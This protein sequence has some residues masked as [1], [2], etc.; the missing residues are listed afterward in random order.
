MVSLRKWSIAAAAVLSWS[1]SLVS[2]GIIRHDVSDQTY[3]D[4]AQESQFQAVGFI[5][6]TTSQY[7]YSASG[8]LINNQWVLT[9]GHVVDGALSMNF[10]INGAVYSAASWVANP[11]WTGNLS[12]GYDIAL[13]KLSS[14]VQGVTAATRYRGTAEKGKVATFV[15]YGMTGTGL[16]GATTFDG[17]KRAGRNVLDVVYG[18]SAGG[19]VFGVDF[20]NPNGTGNVYGGGALDLEY[21]ISYGDSGGAAYIQENGAWYLAGVHSFGVDY[22]RDGLD[23]NYGDYTG[24]TR[25]SSFNSW[26]DSVIGGTGS[27]GTGGTG[28]G[29]GGPKGREFIDNDNLVVAPPVPEPAT[30]ALASMGLLALM[31]RRRRA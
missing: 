28:G 21:A 18:G 20:D 11:K 12:S 8:T 27:G 2:A 7:N 16:T 29:K 26:I 30:A 13:I 23:D 5:Q 17:Q 25:V 6:G 31:P 1:A 3:L 24:H 9:A 22:N 14:A 4:L 10:T 19:R 15:G